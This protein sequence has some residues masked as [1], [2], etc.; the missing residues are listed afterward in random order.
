M[1]KFLVI[2]R[3]TK[4]DINLRKNCAQKG[5]TKKSD[6]KIVRVLYLQ[7]YDDFKLIRITGQA[8]CHGKTE[9]GI[10]VKFKKNGKTSVILSSEPPS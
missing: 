1:T 6:Q 8:A 3:M 10:F 7:I 2:L 4:F 9:H 5:L